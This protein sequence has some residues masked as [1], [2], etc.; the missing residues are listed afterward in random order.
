MSAS[1]LLEI[2][3][4]YIHDINLL[5][6]NMLQCKL[7][8]RGPK[9]SK[10]PQ[11]QSFYSLCFQMTVFSI[12]CSKVFVLISL[13]YF[14]NTL[15]QK[16]VQITIKIQ[17]FLTVVTLLLALRVSVNTFI[18]ASSDQLIK[19]MNQYYK[20]WKWRYFF[21]VFIFYFSVFQGH[22]IVFRFYFNFI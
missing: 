1:Q 21:H 18:N 6:Y 10:Y 20:Y 19:E 4:L 3:W 15:C 12:S 17:N 16:S 7:V 13:V 2:C 11:H 14:L 22:I 8:P 9:W 5:F